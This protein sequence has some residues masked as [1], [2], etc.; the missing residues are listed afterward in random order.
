[1]CRLGGGGLGKEEV[2]FNNTDCLVDFG[3][4]VA[5]TMYFPRLDRVKHEQVETGTLEIT[6]TF[7]NV[8][9]VKI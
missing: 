3:S 2:P 9:D 5:R 6:N 4:V 7:V 8:N 1:M